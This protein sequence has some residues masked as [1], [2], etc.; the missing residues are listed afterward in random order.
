MNVVDRNGWVSGVRRIESPNQ[1]AR[2]ASMLISM[3]VVHAISLPPTQFGSDDIVRLFTNTL[4]PDAHPYFSKI[5]ALR[6]SAHFLIP[7]TGE[8]IQ[9]V[10]CQ[11]RA[12]HSGVSSWKGRERCND[13]SIGVE[14]EGCDDQ[15]FEDAQY[16]RL[17]DLI[18]TLRTSYPIDIVVGHSDISPGRKTDPGPCFDW[19]RLNRT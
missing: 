17:V 4:D 16:I 1:D 15:P 13:Y 5:A 8:L 19:S 11:R 10:S 9:L 7:R 3:I 12:W 14:L 18:E 2:P 6:V